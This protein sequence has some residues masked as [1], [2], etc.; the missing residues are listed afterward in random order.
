M[1]GVGIQLVT[2][3]MAQ[4]QLHYESQRLFEPTVGSP[5]VVPEI[6]YSFQVKLLVALM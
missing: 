4:L 5:D 6:K 2:K 3:C 1:I